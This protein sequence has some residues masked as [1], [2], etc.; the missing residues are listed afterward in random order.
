MAAIN[1]TTETFWLTVGAQKLYN[2]YK[3]NVPRVTK[4][5][6]SVAK[7]EVTLQIKL[8]LPT[9]LFER[10]QLVAEI[11]V[12]PDDV[13]QPVITADVVNNIVE[14]ARVEGIELIITAQGDE[15]G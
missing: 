4:R 9:A 5:R 13:S 8:S 15:D 10:P 1:V 2:S 12:D 14:M 3:L 11:V 7:N 6:P